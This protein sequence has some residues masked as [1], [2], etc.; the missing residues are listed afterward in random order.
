MGEFNFGLPKDPDLTP[1]Q[2]SAINY[3][4]AIALKGGPGTG[5]SVVSLY[6]HIIKNKNGI[7]CQLLTYTT[8][9]AFY[10]KKCCKSESTEAANKIDSTY[11]W[12]YCNKKN[13][14]EIIVDEAQDIELDKYAILTNYCSNLSFGADD[15]QSL[16]PDQGCTVSEL[17]DKFKSNRAFTLSRN[18]RNTKKIMKLAFDAFPNA[19]IPLNEIDSCSEEGNNPFLLISNGSKFDRSNSKQDN[20]ILDIIKEYHA[21]GHNIAILCPSGKDVQY[22]YDHIH[23][24]Y[25]DCSYYYRQT[26]SDVG[27]Q[28][29]SNI[30]ITTFKS[31][32]GLE[33]DTVII[34]NFHKAFDDNYLGKYRINWKDYYVGITRARNNLFLISNNS[35]SKIIN[36]VEL[37]NL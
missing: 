14:K 13:R 22:F 25:S 16:Y 32:K 33:F 20:A 5:K 8:T 30:H 19:N 7:D 17:K 15:N 24:S 12:L 31:A 27:I 37:E 26:D 23:S 21:D 29:I 6:R 28:E 4:N 10:L 35:I 3:P 36:D 1:D 2:R 11:R 34:P 9:L 18:F